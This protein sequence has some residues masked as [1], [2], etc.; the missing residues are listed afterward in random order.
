M[1]YLETQCPKPHD[2]PLMS[3][4]CQLMA[5]G[6]DHLWYMMDQICQQKDTD[7]ATMMDKI[8]NSQLDMMLVDDAEDG[9]PFAGYSL[10]ERTRK[11]KTEYGEDV[12]HYVKKLHKTLVIIV[13]PL[14]R[15]RYRLPKQVWTL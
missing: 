4:N 6:H 3:D 12:F 10:M 7:S 14:W 9:E 5:N 11:L 2:C 8:P 15:K 1:G 13:L